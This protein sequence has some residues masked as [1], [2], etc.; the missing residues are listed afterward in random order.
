MGNLQEL[1][2]FDLIDGEGSQLCNT[3]RGGTVSYTDGVQV[4]IDTL[5]KW[6]Y[7]TK[8]GVQADNFIRISSVYIIGKEIELLFYAPNSQDVMLQPSTVANSTIWASINKTQTT[9]FKCEEGK[10]YAVAFD[11]SKNPYIVFA[12][13]TRDGDPFSYGQGTKFRIDPVCTLAR[14][15]SMAGE[16]TGTVFPVTKTSGILVFEIWVVADV[17][18]PCINIYDPDGQAHLIARSLEY[19]IAPMI[20]DDVPAP[21]ATRYDGIIDQ[22]ESIKD[23]DPTTVQSFSNTT[24]ESAMDRMQGTGMS[25]TWSFLDT[26]TKVEAAA[27]NLYTLFE[28]QN[29]VVETVYTCGPNETPKL[30]AAAK[31]GYI[32]AIRYSYTDQGSYTISVTVGPK[33]SQ[34]SIVQVDGGPTPMMVEDVSAKGTIIQ[35]AGD[36]INFKVSINGYGDRWAICMTSN[37][38]RVGDVVQCSVHNN[39]VEY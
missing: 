35:S 23:N 37:I 33:L 1:N 12:K 27:N 26:E 14:K 9:T 21:I 36:N 22:S 17:E 31:G 39:P 30:G 18:T 11:E 38:L 15:N 25:V 6:R 32:N 8:R 34:N 29:N 28:S 19:H 16:F 3:G 2:N 20:S 7:Q 24:L 5:N 4:S 10:H 13:I